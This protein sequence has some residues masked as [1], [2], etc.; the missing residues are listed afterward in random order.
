[1]T[2]E[3]TPDATG[4][5]G[6]AEHMQAILTYRTTDDKP[7]YGTA[8][9]SGQNTISI[10]GGARNGIVNLVVAVTNSN[11]DSGGDDGSNKGF[12]GQETFNYKARIVSGGTIAPASTRPW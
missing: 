1:V 12:D 8:F 7:V 9:S 11:A 5:K 2:V 6:T 4:S 3:L 10:P